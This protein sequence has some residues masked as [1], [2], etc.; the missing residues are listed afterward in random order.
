[1]YVEQFTIE[2]LLRIILQLLLDI[3]V[4][5]VDATK[6]HLHS[7][8]HIDAESHTVLLTLRFNYDTRLQAVYYLVDNSNRE[9]T[10]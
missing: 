7:Y 8:I 3:A 9:R 6:T 5:H 4:V 1:M 10:S 2:R